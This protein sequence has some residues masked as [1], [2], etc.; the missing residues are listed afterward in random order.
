MGLFERTHENIKLVREMEVCQRIFPFS[1][2]LLIHRIIV[3]IISKIKIAN[4]Y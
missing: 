2:V 3:L 1:S 4:I